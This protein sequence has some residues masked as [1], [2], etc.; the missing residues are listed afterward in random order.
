MRV[1][2]FIGARRKQVSLLFEVL[3]VG[4]ELRDHSE[5]TECFTAPIGNMSDSDDDTVSATFDTS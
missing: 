1:H 5:T 2:F 4:S 3:A